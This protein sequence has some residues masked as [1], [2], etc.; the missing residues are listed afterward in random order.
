MPIVRKSEEINIDF[1]LKEASEKIYVDYIP[2]VVYSKKFATIKISRDKSSIKLIDKN[3]FDLLSVINGN[4]IE[5]N[6][7]EY[8]EISGTYS[9]NERNGNMTYLFELLINEFGFIILSDKQHSTPGSKEFWKS[10]IKKRKFEIFRI[11]IK[12]NYKRKAYRYKDHQIWEDYTHPPFNFLLQDIDFNN[13]SFQ[14]ELEIQDTTLFEIEEL[15][16]ITIKEIEK[17]FGARIDY[18]KDEQNMEDI[19]L[20]AQKYN[21]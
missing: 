21:K 12:T 3:Q 17:E 6:K 4:I 1:V 11:N 2:K 10:H 16:I 14:E 20:I 19:R 13:S 5:Y 9:K 8:F 18:K 15:D 7:I